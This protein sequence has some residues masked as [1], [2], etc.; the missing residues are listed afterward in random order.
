MKMHEDIWYR[1][2]I[3]NDVWGIQDFAFRLMRTTNKQEREQADI[4][5]VDE[6]ICKYFQTL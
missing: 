1:H 6:K 2:I 4:C 5:I 3:V